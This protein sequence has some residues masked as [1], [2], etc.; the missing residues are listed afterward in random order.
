[1]MAIFQ[2]IYITIALI[3]GFSFFAC[4]VACTIIAFIQRRKAKKQAE[5]LKTANSTL[6]L[7]QF[8]YLTA[9]N[10]NLNERNDIE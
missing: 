3:G 9:I 7:S 8:Q 2:S 1:M 6:D 5:G 4:V 10:K